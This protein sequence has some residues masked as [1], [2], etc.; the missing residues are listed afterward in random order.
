MTALKIICF[1]PFADQTRRKGLKALRLGPSEDFIHCFKVKIT[2][3]PFSFRF[4][5]SKWIP[6]LT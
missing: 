4:E 6:E 2:Q 5:T 3:D 1:D